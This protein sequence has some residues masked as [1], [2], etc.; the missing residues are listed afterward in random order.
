VAESAHA[1]LLQANL[2]LIRM[3]GAELRANLSRPRAELRT[4][5]VNINQP[6]G[7][8]LS[9]KVPNIGGFGSTSVDFCSS[10]FPVSARIVYSGTHA[11]VAED[12]TAPLANLMDTLYQKIGAEFDNVMFDIVRTNFGDPLRMD[13]VLD[14]NGKIL[15]L[16]S[17]KVNSFSTIA[18]FVVTCD[19]GT[20]QQYPSSNHTEVFYARVPTDPGPSFGS[21]DTRAGWYRFTRSTIVHEVKHIASFA[22]RI[23]DFGQ[24]AEEP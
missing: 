4:A 18:G 8:I 2:D 5:A 1:R 16:F 19:F 7:T 14:G 6:V 15:M 10:N 20:V 12:I 21:Q 22:T 9:L 13:D 23:R 17:P 3:H 24:S 11:V